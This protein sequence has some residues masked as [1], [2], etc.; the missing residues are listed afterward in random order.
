MCCCWGGDWGDGSD[1]VRRGRD[2]M[3]GG[4]G[5]GGVFIV[6]ICYVCCGGEYVFYWEEFEL[7]LC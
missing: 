2:E 5:G 7:D 6:G 4:V 3:G 1:G